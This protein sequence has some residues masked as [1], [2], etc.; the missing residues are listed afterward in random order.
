MAAASLNNAESVMP[1]AG[2][3]R[4]TSRI[5][6][7]SVMIPTALALTWLGDW[8]FALMII[9]CA[10]LLGREWARLCG[11][12]QT[13]LLGWALPA[14]VML[15]M[16]STQF[17]AP[18]IVAGMIG[19]A[20]MIVLFA[21]VA[22]RFG[23]RTGCWFALGVAAILPAGLSLLW[24]RGIP[25]E[26][27]PLIGWLMLAVWASDSSAYAVGRFIGGPLLAP[28][29]S[30]SKTWSGL[31]GGILGAGLAGYLAALLL[32]TPTPGIAL[33]AGLVVGVAAML[34]D[35]CESRVKRTFKAKD[36]GGLI[37]G[38]G[39]VLDRLDSLLAAAPVIAILYSAGWRW[40]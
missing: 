18:H 27:L 29:L 26:G 16:L 15:L 39:G 34:G 30:P 11:V 38:H 23:A 22:S 9:G 14:G 19:V 3:D 20:L 13:G 7:A 37:P 35:L 31:A 33:L 8:P 12:L 21:P 2:G 5:L 17:N 1:P 28:R 32:S 24:L 40:L 4:L 6:A 25:S 36:S 10:G